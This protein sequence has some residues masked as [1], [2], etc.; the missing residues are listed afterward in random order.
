MNSPFAIHHSPFIIHHSPFTIHS[1]LRPRSLRPPLPLAL[2]RPP[3]LR[4]NSA[5][6]RPYNPHRGPSL[7][8]E[9]PRQKHIHFAEEQRSDGA[10]FRRM[11]EDAGHVAGGAPRR[12]RAHSQPVPS[13][14]AHGERDAVRAGQAAGAAPARALC[15]LLGLLL[16][17]PLL[18]HRAHEESSGVGLRGDHGDVPRSHAA[19][20]DGADRQDPLSRRAGARARS[21][22]RSDPEADADHRRVRAGGVQPDREHGR[23]RH[24]RFCPP[25]RRPAGRAVRRRLGTRHGGRAGDGRGA[26]G[27]PHAARRRRDP[28]R[29]HRRAQS[30]HLP[31]GRAALVLR[32]LLCAARTGW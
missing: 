12:D 28:G 9:G 16:R 13:G 25:P 5:H 2:P 27:L 17:L 26:C 30:H 14:G 18:A 10:L 15:G 22:G 23:R 19:A 24:L 11:A 29:D 1:S 21:A 7:R 8:L 4:Q 32:R 20:G 31:D 3:R 6:S